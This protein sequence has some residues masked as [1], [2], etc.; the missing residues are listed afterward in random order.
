MNWT[1]KLSEKYLESV[2]IACKECHMTAKLM[3]E[4][5]T[6]GS[7]VLHVSVH[8]I[9]GILADM[10]TFVNQID[11]HWAAGSTTVYVAEPYKDTYVHFNFFLTGHIEVK[12][13]KYDRSIAQ[14]ENI[15]KICEDGGAKIVLEYIGEG[16][17]SEEYSSENDMDVPLLRFTVFHKRFLSNDRNW[18]WEQIDDASHCIAVPIT[19][20]KYILE[21][22]LS[23][24]MENLAPL[25]RKGYYV[26]NGRGPSMP[27]DADKAGEVKRVCKELA[28]NAPVLINVV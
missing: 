28:H 5:N 14:W 13:S 25:I 17:V 12:R 20:Q 21:Y 23:Q 1:P 8:P 16:V 9:S 15:E 2:S 26:A 27:E 4:V 24:I 19:T 11:G 6:A 22:L 18:E 10:I 3:D 7:N